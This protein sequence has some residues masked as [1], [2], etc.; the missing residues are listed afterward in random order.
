[1]A[2]K[3]EILSLYSD[4]HMA[5]FK[6]IN[7]AANVD[8]KTGT[9]PADAAN[10][11]TQNLPRVADLESIYCQLLYSRDKTFVPLVEAATDEFLCTYR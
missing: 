6:S 4:C 5:W 8:T 11:L 10:S 2:I 7:E 3:F 1:M 9:M